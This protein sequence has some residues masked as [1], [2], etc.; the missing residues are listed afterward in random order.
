MNAKVWVFGL[1]NGEFFYQELELPSFNNIKDIIYFIREKHPEIGEFYISTYSFDNILD[2]DSE[3]TEFKICY[4]INTE[5][6]YKAINLNHLKIYLKE[7]NRDLYNAINGLNYYNN[8]G[9]V[10]IYSDV[11]EKAYNKLGSVL[12]KNVLEKFKYRV[13]H[14]LINDYVLYMIDDE[15]LKKFTDWVIKVY[16][17]G[18]KNGK[19]LYPDYFLRVEEDVYKNKMMLLTFLN[20]KENLIN[21]GISVNINDY[22]NFSELFEAIRKYYNP[23][24]EEAKDLIAVIDDTRIYEDDNILVCVPNNYYQ[25][26]VLGKGTS[27][28]TAAEETWY[29]DYTQNDNKLV[30]FIEKEYLDENYKSTDKDNEV[31]KYQYSTKTFD[32]LNQ[33]DDNFEFYNTDLDLEFAEK[34]ADSVD[35]IYVPIHFAKEFEID[36]DFEEI[37]EKSPQNIVRIIY[38]IDEKL[39]CKVLKKPNLIDN[40]FYDA[41]YK[42]SKNRRFLKLNTKDFDDNYVLVS[43]M[44]KFSDE[45]SSNIIKNKEGRNIVVLDLET[46]YDLYY[47]NVTTYGVDVNE[48]YIE[49]MDEEGF[50]EFASFVLSAGE[51]GEYIDNEIIYNI[52]ERDSEWFID[53]IDMY[54]TNFGYNE[55]LENILKDRPELLTNDVFEHMFDMDLTHYLINIFKEN[56]DLFEEMI[57]D[58]KSSKRGEEFIKEFIE[59]YPD[60]LK[61]SVIVETLEEEGFGDI[62]SEYLGEEEEE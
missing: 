3:Y 5:N 62:I 58:F 7:N 46:V 51:D 40:M 50:D 27:W 35:S 55:D 47:V 19:V 36:I 20:N 12:P 2:Y 32:F 8:E 42:Y 17:F 28:C 37:L 59:E 26:K 57:V 16:S 33:S 43:L 30:I 24:K 45:I 52:A 11:E 21:D 53:F 13:S 10:S 48:V 44:S 61:N 54:Y 9:C 31:G 25:S 18:I 23:D 38:Y 6:K 4:I 15:R 56:N 29:D 14:R 34:Y 1:K 49:K 39:V 41:T 60:I 22:K